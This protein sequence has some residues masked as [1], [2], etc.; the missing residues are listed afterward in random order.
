MLGANLVSVQKL[1]GHSDPKI[2]ERRYGHLLPDFMSAEVNR[3]KFGLGGLVPTGRDSQALAGLRTQG[4]TPELQSATPLRG[5]AGTPRISPSDSGLFN[6]GEYGTRIRLSS[7]PDGVLTSPDPAESDLTAPADA[8]ATHHTASDGAGLPPVVP[9]LF[10]RAAATCAAR[11]TAGGALVEQVE[12]IVARG[13]AQAARM[14]S[15]VG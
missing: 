7:R 13:A 10:V 6:G 1:L 2:T 4:V 5:E 8:L 15:E 11:A 14:M 12:A 3:L 9:E